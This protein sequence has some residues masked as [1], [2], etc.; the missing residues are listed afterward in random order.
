MEFVISYFEKMNLWPV[1]QFFQHICHHFWVG[2]LGA[3]ANPPKS[4]DK[5]V[6]KSFQLV[7][8]SSFR[9]DLL[10][11]PYFSSPWISLQ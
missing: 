10:Q 1:E 7:R 2:L 6:K 11:N 9:N 4:D 5:Y 8:S 3:I